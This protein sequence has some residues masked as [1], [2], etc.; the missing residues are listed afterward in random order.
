MALSRPRG[1]STAG[2]LVALLLIA[3]CN[4]LP[5]P[6]T[7]PTGS[8]QPTLAVRSPVP[9]TSPP[10]SSPTLPTPSATPAERPASGITAFALGPL[11]GEWALAI[12][13]PRPLTVPPALE[14]S[15]LWAVPM[16]GGEPRLA[17][18]FVSRAPDVGGVGTGAGLT[19]NVL[20]RQLAPDGRRVLLNV[21][22]P[23]AIGWRLSLV[24]VDLEGGRVQ[25]IGADDRDHDRAGAWSPDGQRIAYVRRP[26]ELL[27]GM[28]D[29][30]LWVMS[31]DGTAPRRIV[32]NSFGSFTVLLDW[33]QDSRTVTFAYAFEE[34]LMRSVNVDTGERA[35]M[36]Y[37][38]GPPLGHDWR[39]RTPTF[40]GAFY[41]TPRNSPTRLSTADRFGAPER[42]LVSQ[43]APEEPIAGARW[44]PDRDLVLFRREAALHLIELTTGQTRRLPTAKAVI[45]AEW[46]PDGTA[47]LYVANEPTGLLAATLRVIGLDGTA[48]RELLRPRE[49][50]IATDVAARRYR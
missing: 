19:Q 45:Q 27:L 47:I 23:R 8:A 14:V 50:M 6:P 28:F 30:G 22:T 18:R 1:F 36:G 42:V 16:A 34:A 29:D 38:G 39:A 33:A 13:E 12:V 17:A 25:M 41:D 10:G 46:S 31:S 9:S 48:D 7:P 40:V 15:E 3:A 24:I 44:H 37:V 20:R 43:P 21:L 2:L 5:S 32:P 26:D 11:S 35:L 49:G 4:A